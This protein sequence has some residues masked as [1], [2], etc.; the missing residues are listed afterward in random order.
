MLS[1]PANTIVET[2]TL[3]DGVFINYARAGSGAHYLLCLPGSLGTWRCC[4]CKRT[5]SHRI[6]GHRLL[7]YTGTFRRRH[8]Y[9]CRLGSARLWQV[10]AARPSVQCKLERHRR[11]IRAR[12]DDCKC[13]CAVRVLRAATEHGAL[14]VD[15]LVGRRR[16]SAVDGTQMASECALSGNARC[17]GLHYGSNDA[18]LSK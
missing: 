2:K 9:R 3:V 14:F 17:D 15:R 12:T 11:R 7:R 18:N 8:I 4:A 16:H 1:L 5:H 6:M 10:P 13:V